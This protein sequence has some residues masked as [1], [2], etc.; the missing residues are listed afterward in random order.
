METM[1]KYRFDKEMVAFVKKLD[2]KTSMFGYDK[3]DVYS[4]FK[5]LLVKARDV[6]EELVAEEHQSVEE[7]KTSLVE[8]AENPLKLEALLAQWKGEKEPEE[9]AGADAMREMNPAETPEPAELT[10]AALFQAEDTPPEEVLEESEQVPDAIDEKEAEQSA[11]SVCPA[12]ELPATETD[13]ALNGVISAEKYA[14]LETAYQM[15]TEEKEELA[16]KLSETAWE[17]QELQKQI[18]VYKEREEELNRTTDILREARLEGEMVYRAARTRA[19]QELFLYR[20]KRRDEEKAFGEMIKCLESRK[21]NLAE[22]CELY[23][24]Y[25][26]EGQ[27][28]FEQMRA[29]AD[30]LEHPSSLKKAADDRE[31]LSA[32]QKEL[33]ALKDSN[34]NSHRTPADDD[35]R[36]AYLPWAA[37]Y[38]EPYCEGDVCSFDADKKVDWLE[39][40]WTAN[41]GRP[42]NDNNHK[43]FTE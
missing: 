20:A 35:C 11:V 6:C 22:T 23:Q 1:I 3:G 10:E 31:A 5:E 26:E 8:A 14:E 39:D 36:E 13:V 42:E 40:L 7:M 16:G 21:A 43:F 30:R 2:I 4:K 18:S 24:N 12:E 41:G 33:D 17:M 29:Y 27:A 9:N 34:T 25:V 32:L 15:L 37:P 38:D 28:L 19:V